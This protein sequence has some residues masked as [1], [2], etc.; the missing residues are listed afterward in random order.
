VTER[1]SSPLRRMNS[2]I[3]AYQGIFAGTRIATLGFAMTTAGLR[4]PKPLGLEVVERPARRMVPLP[5]QA[6]RGLQ[7]WYMELSKESPQRRF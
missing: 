3:E 2:L 6:A 4:R 1:V 7:P 5:G